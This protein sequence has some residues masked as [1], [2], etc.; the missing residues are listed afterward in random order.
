MLKGLLA[1]VGLGA[2]A[3]VVWPRPA[4]LKPAGIG[5]PD[6]ITANG[7]VFARFN[8]LFPGH[9]PVYVDPQTGDIMT[10]AMASRD[11]GVINVLA[12]KLRTTPAPLLQGEQRLA[13]AD[14]L[15]TFATYHLP[16][17]QV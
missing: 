15:M 10:R 14:Y 6:I 8:P 4:R 17:L 2:I 9:R 16:P 3:W 11:R 13:A 12:E 7:K 1:L 5:T